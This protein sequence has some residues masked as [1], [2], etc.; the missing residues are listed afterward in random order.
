[1]TTL[2]TSQRVPADWIS[3]HRGQDDRRL[4]LQA[5]FDGLPKLRT[6]ALN[7]ARQTPGDDSGT[8]ERAHAYI[9]FGCGGV[10]ERVKIDWRNGTR[11]SAPCDSVSVFLVFPAP[12]GE[13]E[14]EPSPVATRYTASVGEYPARSAATFT[15][16]L[17]DLAASS[18]TVVRIPDY[19][20]RVWFASPLISEKSSGGST[21]WLASNSD[22]DPV[23]DSLPLAD[24][25]TNTPGLRV[26]GPARYIGV[27]IGPG[28][29][30]QQGELV[31]GMGAT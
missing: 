16:W 5:D 15:H 1:V 27:L 12:G 2:G 4:V 23:I 14:A 8:E 19:A 21:L 6:V 30:I 26:F 11:Y 24:C 17:G 13:S 28:Q 31:F 9:D 3:A 20:E 22:M 7:V 10:T 29:G 25:W 18:Q